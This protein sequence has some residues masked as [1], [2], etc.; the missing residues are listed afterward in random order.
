MKYYRHQFMKFFFDYLN[1]RLYHFITTIFRN[2]SVTRDHEKMYSPVMYSKVNKIKD[3]NL[4]K[5]K[6]HTIF[7]WIT[8]IKSHIFPFFDPEEFL[9]WSIILYAPLRFFRQI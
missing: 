4:K 9:T 2:E 8:V 3:K 7:F 1:I 6:K 5:Y